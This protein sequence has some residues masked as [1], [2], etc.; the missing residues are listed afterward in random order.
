MAR[1]ARRR[2]AAPAPDSS[3]TTTSEAPISMSESRPNPASATDLA[4]SAATA[5]TT[6]PTRFQPSVANSSAKPA[7][8]IRA[9][10]VDA[11]GSLV[12]IGEP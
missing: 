5:S 1:S 10:T 2:R 7:R 9:S 4:A 11:A 3:H 12:G 6:I 8:I